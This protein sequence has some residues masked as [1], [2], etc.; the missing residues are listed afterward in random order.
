MQSTP[1]IERIAN[2]AP[3]E[4]QEGANPQKKLSA[5]SGCPSLG[6]RGGVPM[7]KVDIYFAKAAL[8]HPPASFE[9]V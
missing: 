5:L 7:P 9:D 3:K 2:A 6:A 4:I 8:Q 1:N